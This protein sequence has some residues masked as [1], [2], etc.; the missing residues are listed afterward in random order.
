MSETKKSL[1]DFY[2]TKVKDIMQTS[3]TVLPCVEENADVD[4]VFSLLN[5][6]DHVWV[7]DSKNPTHVLGVITK[8]D[9]IALLSPPVVSLQTFDKPDS[10]SLQF[11]DPLTAQE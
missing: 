7:I 10:R 3:K 1:H 9:T 6:K 4:L 5:K 2:E 11:G 8:S